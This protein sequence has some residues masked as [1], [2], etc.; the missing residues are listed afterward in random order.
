MRSEMMSALAVAIVLAA[1]GTMLG[2]SPQYTIMEVARQSTAYGINNHG[3]IVLADGTSAPQRVAIWQDGVPTQYINP[4]PGGDYA[5]VNGSQ[6]IN[7]HGDVVGEF[8]HPGVNIPF[9]YSNGTVTILPLADAMPFG[10]N[11]N[12]QIVG[13][14]RTTQSAFLYQNGTVSHPNIPDTTYTTA[15]AISDSGIIVGYS[16]VA[17][18]AYNTNDGWCRCFPPTIPTAV[19]AKRSTPAGWSPST[20]A[21]DPGCGTPSTRRGRTCRTSLASTT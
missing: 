18:Y 15:Y 10:I 4:P 17:A 7:D 1:A 12:G 11:N 14:D 6:S 8:G 9:L 5:Y 3:Q 19:A 21:M 2:Q 20:R 13:Y 16:D